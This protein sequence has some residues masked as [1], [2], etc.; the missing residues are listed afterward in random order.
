[1]K[2]RL[3]IAVEVKLGGGGASDGGFAEAESLAEQI[4]R[5]DREHLLVLMRQRDESKK[6]WLSNFLNG[7]LH[8]ML[9]SDKHNLESHITS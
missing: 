3:P 8:S 2:R 6:T 4:K 5:K 1:M 7:E 9:A